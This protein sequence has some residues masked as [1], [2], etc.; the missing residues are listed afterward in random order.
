[1]IDRSISMLPQLTLAQWCAGM[2]FDLPVHLQDHPIS[3]VALDS[4]EVTD[5]DCFLVYTLH[6]NHAHQHGGRYIGAALA[7]GAGLVLVDAA[8]ADAELQI[9]PQRAGLVLR[10]DGLRCAIGEL[11]ARFFGHPSQH[12]PLV[13]ITGTNGKSSCA[14]FLAQA[15]ALAADNGHELRQGG[16][17]GT[18][19]WGLLDDLQD[20][21][22]TT[23]DAL[24][25]QWRL[26]RL[27]QLQPELVA[28]EASSHALEQRRTS[29]CHFRVAAITNL[30]Q[31]HLDYH[32]NMQAYAAAKLKLFT[33][34]QVEHMLVSLDDAYCR[35]MHQQ[36]LQLG[37]G[38][39]I[40]TTSTQ[41]QLNAD[42]CVQAGTA[43]QSTAAKAQRGMRIQVRSPWGAAELQTGLLGHFN[44]HN[45]A[46]VVGCLGTLGWRWSRIAAVLQALQPVPGRMQLLPGSRRQPL[47]IV[48]YAHTPDALHTV[49]ISAREFCRGRLYC[50]FGCGGDRDRGKRSRMGEIAGRLADSIIITSDNPRH[51]APE[52]I[53]S[54]IRAGVADDVPVLCQPDRRLAITAAL[55]HATAD[56]VVIIAGKGHE[57][58]QQIGHQ[59]LVFDDA[60][61]ATQ[62]AAS[63]QAEHSEQPGQLNN[64]SGVPA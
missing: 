37:H 30:S 23:P 61:I 13:G 64:P 20:S 15:P 5:G 51:E 14:H 59:R 18:L 50:V 11:C 45:L 17:I 25:L 36:L 28:M 6:D 24:Q 9:P 35:N 10:V 16:M 26:A 7:N 1:M 3:G 42:V 8:I 48:D 41:P 46:T 60:A 58:Y 44:L 31:D 43:A 57:R 29:G 55:Q 22:H 49:L 4:R 2:G 39:R 12:L 63:M 56:D 38:E 34:H 33:E 62:I 32:L 52:R 47:I 54:D 27:Q 21:R 40:L 19:G 53:I